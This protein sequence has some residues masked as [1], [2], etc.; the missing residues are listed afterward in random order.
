PQPFACMLR[1][2]DVCPHVALRQSFATP[3]ESHLTDI[4]QPFLRMSFGSDTEGFDMISRRE[5]IAQISASFLTSGRNFDRIRLATVSLLD[6]GADPEKDAFP[7][8]QAAIKHLKSI[9]GGIL[10]FPGNGGRGWWLTQGV[11]I[12]RS[13]IHLRLAEDVRL[14]TNKPS[15][16]F[17]FRGTRNAPIKSVSIAGDGKKVKIDGGGDKVK[18]YVYNTSTYA[19]CVFFGWVSGW[20][21][22]NIYARNGLDGC[23]RAFQCENGQFIDCDASNSI[24]DNGF[25]IDFNLNPNATANNTPRQYI[26][27]CRAWKC[28]G[29]G[30]TAYCSTNTSI[31]NGSVWECGNDDPQAPVSGGGISSE[32]DYKNA[33]TAS[34]DRNIVISNCTVRNCMN[35]GIFVTTGQTHIIDVVISNTAAASRRKND[36]TEKGSGIYFISAGSGSVINTKIENS[37]TNGVTLVDNNGYVPNLQ[38]DGSIEHSTL[39]G[40]LVRRAGNVTISKRSMISNSGKQPFINGSMQV[41]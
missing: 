25:S 31:V 38:F 16:V 28:A 29:F 12:D 36:M 19:P 34:I 17:A 37:G 20:K 30:M 9:G 40:I 39:Y 21:A 23:F 26:L 15:P 3:T 1:A 22:Q 33:A 8:A 32:G 35:A 7:A 14:L 10:E 24:Y 41:Q 5:L 27:N 4:T 11:V 13:N 18:S 6:F 2:G